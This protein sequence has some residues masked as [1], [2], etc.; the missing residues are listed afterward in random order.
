[1]YITS[2]Y[3]TS[4][5]ITSQYITSQYITSQY[6]KISHHLSQQNIQTTIQN[7]GQSFFEEWCLNEYF[8]E[9]AQKSFKKTMPINLNIKPIQ[10]IISNIINEN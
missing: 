7:Y 3:I 8:K 6:Q 2:Q 9:M 4:Q 1:M 5:Y 10:K